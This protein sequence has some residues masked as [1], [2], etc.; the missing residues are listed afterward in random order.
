[1]D[2]DRRGEQELYFLEALIV[3]RFNLKMIYVPYTNKHEMMVYNSTNTD[4]ESESEEVDQLLQTDTEQML[5]ELNLKFGPAI[6]KYIQDLAVSDD[7]E[8]TPF[9]T[10][11]TALQHTNC[12]TSTWH[13]CQR[14]ELQH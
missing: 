11:L 7:A 4:G 10:A 12:K 1:M 9:D 6:E 14:I 5:S 3:D 8:Q 13:E 2:I